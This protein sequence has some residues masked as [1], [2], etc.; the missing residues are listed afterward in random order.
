MKKTIFTFGT[1]LLLM[2]LNLSVNGQG[3]GDKAPDFTYTDLT[4]TT[5]SLADYSGKVV[6]LF[7]FGHSCPYCEAIGNDTE[8]KVNQVYGKKSD[9]QAL[10]L[11][12]WSNSSTATVGAFQATT[13]ITYPL[14]LQAKSFEQLY[15]SSY[16]RVIVIDREGV[17]RHKN[18]SLA[19]AKDLANAIAVLEGLYLT[20]D[21]D[22]A[23]GGFSEGLS[24]VYPNPSS[25]LVNIRF[26]TTTHDRVNIRV[27]NPLG[28]EVNRIIDHDLPAGEHEQVLIVSDLSPGVYFI[29]METAGSTWVRKFQV[30][31]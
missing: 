15:S 3:V 22:D 29:R 5:H 16:D 9:F 23:G 26:T 10:G 18:N 12:T 6:F 7:V 24:E 14:L 8:T 27:F 17:I 13:Q 4:G 21:V 31:R 1:F 25:D 30:S 28:Q 2:G 19:T 20:M 11:D